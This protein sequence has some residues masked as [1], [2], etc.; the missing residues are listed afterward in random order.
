MHES[1]RRTR[2][3]VL[4]AAAMLAAVPVSAGA[5]DAP[6]TPITAS[7]PEI[8]QGQGWS[9]LGGSTSGDG[10]NVLAVNVGF[11]SVAVSFFRG[12]TSIQDFG[13][14]IAFNYGYERLV[15][16]IFPGLRAEGLMRLR[17]LDTG[18]VNL[19]VKGGVGVFAY[20]TPTFTLPGISIPLAVA[21]G[22]PVGSAVA[23]S[24]GVDLP[25]FITFG[26]TGGFSVPVLFNAGLEYWLDKR[27]QTSLH[28]KMG[29][30]LNTTGPFVPV[31]SAQIA[32]EV[33][34]GTA[35]KL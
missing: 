6:D 14:R 22:I 19:G 26:P 25:L 9:L 21:V 24:T 34:L 28:F 11:P 32:F 10:A 13:L 29:P 35:I 5:A 18:R 17:L 2:Q 23:L 15:T 7:A 30:L 3:A 31:G 16:A 27:W 4:V 20:F 1:T 33:G 8:R 12:V